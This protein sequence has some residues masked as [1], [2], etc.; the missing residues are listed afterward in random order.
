MAR[1]TNRWTGATGSEFRIIGPAQ[2]FGNAVARSTQPL[3]I[4]LFRNQMNLPSEVK[5]EI[6]ARLLEA[7]NG[8]RRSLSTDRT[9]VLVDEVLAT[10]VM[11][12]PTAICSWKRMT[13]RRT[14]HPPLIAVTV[15]KY[16]SSFWALVACR[17]SQNSFRSYHSQR[18]IVLSATAQGART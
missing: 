13:L 16:R 5:T 8:G 1:P 12:L 11:F 2:L 17:N 4:F 3:G 18:T 9:A 10:V 15:R 14:T 7:K 6:Q